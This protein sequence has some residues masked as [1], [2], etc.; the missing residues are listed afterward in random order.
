VTWIPTVLERDHDK[1]ETP[2]R[3]KPRKTQVTVPLPEKLI[4]SLNNP[5]PIHMGV[6]YTIDVYL[7]LAW[8]KD[9]KFDS[10]AGLLICTKL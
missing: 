5:L 7:D 3:R 9:P 6:G 10:P 1:A 8:K 2:D 4:P